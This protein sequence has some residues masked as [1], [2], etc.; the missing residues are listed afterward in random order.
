MKDANIAMIG[1]EEQSTCYLCGNEG[2][3]LYYNLEDRIF[4][5]PGSWTL[6][7]CVSAECGLVWL[8]PMP[9]KNEIG[10]AYRNYYTHSQARGYKRTLLSKVVKL[11]ARPLYTSLL[12]LGDELKQHKCMY[13]DS[14]ATGQ[15]LLDVGCGNGERL[16]YMR[17]LGWEV[18]GQE[19]DSVAVEHVRKVY[20]IDVYQGPMQALNEDLGAGIFD[21]IIMHHVIEHVHDP[22]A[23]LSACF[24]LLKN[25]GRIVIMTP[26][27][28]SFGHQKLGSTWR[29]LEPPRHLHL[30]TC[31][32]LVK[33]SNMAGFNLERCWTTAVN[34]RVFE[35]DSSINMLPN[36]SC[37]VLTA[38][39]ELRSL[40][41]QIAASSTHKKNSTSGEE[42]IL[43]ATK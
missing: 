38:G 7:R 43:I 23:L 35:L 40:R 27:V 39:D 42:C 6:K 13:L 25:K 32:A 9:T 18:M 28:E 29:G 30:F 5:S 24:R 4:S 12:S 20:G 15:R 21:A 36:S 33:M 26:N 22:V 19:V 1:T 37:Y 11:I 17:Q 8:D 10:K 16:A 41:F 3:T 34:A 31:R 2:E 14:V